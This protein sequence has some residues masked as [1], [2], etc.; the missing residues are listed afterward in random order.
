[1][2]LKHDLGEAV[3]E[4]WDRWS[5][6]DA[7]RYQGTNKGRG[8]WKGFKPR[9]GGDLIFKLARDAGWK[10]K[11]ARRPEPIGPAGAAAR[12]AI[13]NDPVMASAGLP[14]GVQAEPAP[15]PTAAVVDMA[16]AREAKA[17]KAEKKK[18]KGGP[19]AGDAPTDALRFPFVTDRYVARLGT[20]APR[21]I[22]ENVYWALLQ[23]PELKGL[24]E[25]DEFAVRNNKTRLAPWDREDTQLG[26]WS[27][28]DDL[29]LG[30]Y[31][32]NTH[33]L[34]IGNPQTLQQAIDMAARRIKRNPP[35]EYLEGLTWD[36]TPRLASWLHVY[37]GAD[38]SDYSALAG[39][40]F[41]IGMVARAMEPGCKMDYAL[42]FQGEQGRGKS[43]AFRVLGGDW[44]SE[45]PIKM[46]DKD[47]YLLLQGVWLYEFAEL[48][49]FSKSEETAVKAFITAPDD[50]FRP[51]YGTRPVQMKRRVVFGGTTNSDE[52]L[53][54][55]TGNRR[56]WPVK[57]RNIDLDALKRD[58]DQLFA[59]AVFHYSGPEG[60]ALRRWYPTREEEQTLFVPE[61]D[62]WK[63]VDVWADIIAGYVNGMR[64]LAEDEDGEAIPHDEQRPNHQ[65]DFFS[66]HE[67]LT[68][69][70]TIDPGRIDR[71]KQMQRSV[72]Q[73][74]R[75]LGFEPH[76]EPDG[77]RKR[78]Y[79]RR[80]AASGT[81]APVGD[82]PAAPSQTDG[83]R[84]APD[85]GCP[86]SDS[87][88]PAQR[89]AEL[90]ERADVPL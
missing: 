85:A 64:K 43:S 21:G 78:G 84:T 19:P 52:F 46:G 44:F 57:T 8:R 55:S 69:A 90:L 67:L 76:R 11:R 65:R 40:F 51:P 68:K 16:E 31:L 28:I 41:L 6:L 27:P 29:E 61:Q 15:A 56:Y 26:E 88:S 71:S 47:S 5:A 73:C 59:E 81:P 7:D 38:Q 12:E 63:L 4:H 86:A 34:L 66:T 23:D 39:S 83:P 22:R 75:E 13:V 32:G 25:F 33:E 14:A 72:A 77:K 82:A 74:M 70:L 3:F 18:K 62:R 58:R 24:V 2:I 42:I 53:R 10:A 30:M 17:A 89:A 45:T 36:G 87:L 37:V 48:D 80:D 79:V 60:E 9:A 54:D 35:R 49:S 1:M 50:R 20:Y